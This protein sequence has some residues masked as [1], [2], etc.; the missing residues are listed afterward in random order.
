LPQRGAPQQEKIKDSQDKGKSEFILQLLLAE[1]LK[2]VK[3]CLIEP[4]F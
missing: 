2:P 3:K 1:G 4:V